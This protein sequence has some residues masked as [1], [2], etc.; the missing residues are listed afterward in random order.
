MG[1]ITISS[2]SVKIPFVQAG[3]TA[4]VTVNANNYLDIPVTFPQSFVG[5]PVV[6]VGLYSEST[7]AAIG[8]MSAA[9]NNISETG[10]TIRVFNAG[11]ANRSP[12][13]EWIA[14]EV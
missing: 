7:A 10:F 12:I 2:K 3:E 9:V 4:S 1:N 14:T 11:T 5:K 13:I 8:S 6:V